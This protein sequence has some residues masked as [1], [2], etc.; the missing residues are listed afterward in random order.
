VLAELPV[1]AG[2]AAALAAVALALALS[3]IGLPGGPAPAIA[4][5]LP[6]NCGPTVGAAAASIRIRSVPPQA[7]DGDVLAY[8]VGASYP[9]PAN[10]IGCTVFDVDVFIKTPGSSD[11]LF[12]CNIPSLVSGSG[13]VECSRTSTYVVSAADRT[14]S[15]DLIAAVH[16]MGNKHDRVEDCVFETS[17][18]NPANIDPC[19]DASA[20]S[21]IAEE[22]TPTATAI[23]TDTPVPADTPVP[24]S[25]PPVVD[26][27]LSQV[28]PNPAVV[29]VG[30]I[31]LPDTGA[32]PSGASRTWFV[33]AMVLAGGGMAVA[34]AGRRLKGRQHR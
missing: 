32:G 15:G 10:G 13:T 5:I 8:K 34:G 6:A 33:A 25:A 26:D 12:V 21:R 11:F 29:S 31:A 16:V 23:P 19:F 22:N 4:E 20:I 3:A 30:E 14:G 17:P 24:D 27:V 18:R 9:A 2:G 28:R 7:K 1:A